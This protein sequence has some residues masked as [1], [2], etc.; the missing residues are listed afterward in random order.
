MS[1]NGKPRRNITAMSISDQKRFLRS[2]CDQHPLG[3]NIDAAV[4]LMLNL[5]IMDEDK[6]LVSK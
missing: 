4:D 2:Y 6:P 5:P 1:V 3:S